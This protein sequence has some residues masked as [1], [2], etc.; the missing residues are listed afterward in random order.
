MSKELTGIGKILRIR[1]ADAGWPESRAQG[2]LARNPQ[3]LGIHDT[4]SCEHERGQGGQ[5]LD[6]LFV[7]PSGESLVVVELQ[8]GNVDADHIARLL[9]YAERE[10]S[11]FTDVR[12][13][14]IAEECSGKHGRL[15]NCLA[16]AGLI[17]IYL[18]HVERAHD[19]D[20]LVIKSHDPGLRLAPVADP[21][22]EAMWS[23]KPDFYLV[24]NLLDR[25]VEADPVWRPTY[26]THIGGRRVEPNFNSVAFHGGN[27]GIYSVE[28]KLPRTTENDRSVETLCD[29]WIYKHE[30]K[31]RREH[32]RIKIDRT[33]DD[34]K[35]RRLGDLLV[36]AH[37]RWLREQIAL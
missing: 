28:I 36:K 2:E 32:Y 8:L 34:C 18:M 25:I 21:N 35:M 10:R 16:R 11:E 14:L 5:R 15:A 23:E 31:P 29:S 26:Q 20:K 7:S 19:G 24:A 4:W 30:G 9:E 13:A 27:N 1:L 37:A 3:A 22:F 33:W 12:A 17:E 6:T